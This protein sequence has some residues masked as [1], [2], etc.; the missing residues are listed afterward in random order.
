[1]L[2]LHCP[3]FSDIPY[4]VSTSTRISASANMSRPVTPGAAAPIS[5]S[6]PVTAQSLSHP[7]RPLSPVSATYGP[8][9]APA[10]S[11]SSSQRHVSSASGM[12]HNNQ[13]PNMS[14][15]NS[16]RQFSTAASVQGQNQAPVLSRS[17]TQ[18]SGHAGSRPMSYVAGEGA[19]SETGNRNSMIQ[20]ETSELSQGGFVNDE[21]HIP[22]ND[23]SS[24]LNRSNSQ[25]SQSGTTIPS[26][27]GTLK[28]KASLKKSGSLKRSASKKS[29][30]AGSVRS[31]RLGEKEKY[32][33]NPEHNSVFYC[34][35]PTTGSPTD[36]L[37][38]R[39]QGMRIKYKSRPMKLTSHSMA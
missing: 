30:Y 33:P 27:G 8:H 21:D 12:Q 34:P 16:Q 20:R 15:S 2:P 17:N 14:R 35:V 39:F 25:A 38:D 37:A 3:S 6:T 31:L 4:A 19:N 5:T 26:R 23:A 18:R 22:L 32:E 36:L 7:Q 10:I 28:K 11:R 9:Q 13:A 29:S 24:G 1:M